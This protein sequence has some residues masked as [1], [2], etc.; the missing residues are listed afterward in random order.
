MEFLNSS[1]LSRPLLKKGLYFFD[2]E[3]KSKFNKKYIIGVDEAGR[4]PVA[5]PVV[6]C[7]CIILNYENWMDEINDSK[8]I[9]H[10][11]REKIFKNLVSSPS[12]KLAFSYSTNEEIDKFNILN[13]TLNAMKKA[14]EKLIKYLGNG[15]CKKEFIVAID[16]NKKI[17]TDMDQIYV[18]KGDSKSLSIAA[19]SIFA[20]VIRDRWMNVL[21]LTYPYYNFKKHKGYP[22]KEHIELIKKYGLSPIHR[23]S[24]SPCDV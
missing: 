1:T 14:V 6:S 12:V 4:G 8:K 20:K 19:A 18:I 21:H 5:G 3:I 2:A 22:T 7:A 10:Q 11:K 23:R 17:E 13:A 16:G 24:F 15:Y 9:S